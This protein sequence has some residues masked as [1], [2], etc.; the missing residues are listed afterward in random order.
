MSLHPAVGGLMIHAAIILRNL[1]RLL[2][3]SSFFF[4]NDPDRFCTVG[5][6]KNPE[7]RISFFGRDFDPAPA[8]TSGYSHMPPPTYDRWRCRRMHRSRQMLKET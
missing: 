3:L 1:P 7:C 8:Q 5:N 4:R 2:N 6:R